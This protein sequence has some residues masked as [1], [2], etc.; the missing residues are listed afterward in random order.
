MNR[1]LPLILVVVAVGLHFFHCEWVCR[2]DVSD[3]SQAE[4]ERTIYFDYS[5]HR[6]NSLRLLARESQD[7]Q[8]ATFYGVA[9]PGLLVGGAC[10]IAYFQHHP[11]VASVG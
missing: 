8:E 4:H 3:C 9:L 11:G 6:R 1:F 2:R 7:R 5:R 10:L